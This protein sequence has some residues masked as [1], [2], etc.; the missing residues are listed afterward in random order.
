LYVYS[1]KLEDLQPYKSTYLLGAELAPENPVSI[2]TQGS[3]G[4]KT[5]PLLEV[6]LLWTY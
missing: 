2:S 5:G 4:P 6:A 3:E 1:L